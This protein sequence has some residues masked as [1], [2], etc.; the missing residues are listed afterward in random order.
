MRGW[1]LAG[2]TSLITCAHQTISP[3][4][5][6]VYSDICQ[7]FFNKTR[8]KKKTKINKLGVSLCLLGLLEIQ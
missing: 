3:H 7:L 8:V 2:S 5:L 4:A 1:M 6:N